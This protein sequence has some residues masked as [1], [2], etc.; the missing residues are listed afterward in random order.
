[1]TQNRA[2]EREL[3]AAAPAV[4]EGSGVVLLG[5]VLGGEERLLGGDA[6]NKGLDAPLALA[7]HAQ[8]LVF[9]M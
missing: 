4:D 7:A 8:Q 2:G 3:T 5:T 1:V 6:D 9:I